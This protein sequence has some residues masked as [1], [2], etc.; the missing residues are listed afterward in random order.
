MQLEF[1]TG[2]LVAYQIQVCNILVL[3]NSGSA[4][5]LTNTYSNIAMCIMYGVC[6]P[7][8]PLVSTDYDNR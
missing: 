7:S 1:G 2:S 5:G 6:G 4:E 8:L 3:R